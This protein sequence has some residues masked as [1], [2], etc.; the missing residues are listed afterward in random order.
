MSYSTPA[1]CHLIKIIGQQFGL[2]ASRCE[3]ALSSEKT[4]STIADFLKGDEKVLKLI[5]FYQKRDTYTD[6]GDCIE[7][8]GV[9]RLQLARLGGQDT[10]A[11]CTLA[12]ADHEV[13]QLFL[14]TG[15]LDKQKGPAI[16]FV[17][18]TKPVRAALSR[19][20]TLAFRGHVPGLLWA[21]GSRKTAALLPGP[22]VWSNR[23]NVLISHD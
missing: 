17:R 2:S 16:Y 20:R 5:F 13:P 4:Y 1:Q 22:R 11:A 15:E 23:T 9:L 14:T 12:R 10:H 6:D 18:T 21:G 8:A 3:D 19:P 7:A